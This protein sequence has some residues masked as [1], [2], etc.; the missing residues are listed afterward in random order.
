MQG[1][2][3]RNQFLHLW[4][5]KMKSCLN[6]LLCMMFPHIEGSLAACFT[7]WTQDLTSVLLFNALVNLFKHPQNNTIK[8]HREFS[9]ISNPPLLKEFFTRKT[10]ISKSKRSV[11]LIGHL[12]SCIL[13]R[14]STTGFCIFLGE[15]LISWKTKKQNTVSRSS[16]EAEYRALAA[17]C[18]EVQWV[19]FLLEDLDITTHSTKNLYCDSQSARHIAQ[20]HSFHERT[21]H[22]DI[23]C[24][25]VRERLQQGLFNLLPISTENQP[26]DLLTKPVDNDVFYRLLHK[27]GVLNIHAPAWGGILSFGPF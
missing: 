15:S 5:R 9:G 4:S 21:K 20:N 8:L 18:C 3:V 19:T 13:T 1:C 16:S 12:A 14:R 2:L 6:K 26:A 17:T 27:L 24:H 7:W 25:V 11:T 22:L 23:D 10:Q